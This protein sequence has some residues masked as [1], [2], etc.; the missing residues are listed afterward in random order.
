MEYLKISHV[1]IRC[2]L[3]NNILFADLRC[4]SYIVDPYILR[5]QGLSGL[6]SHAICPQ[7]I[8]NGNDQLVRPGARTSQP[9]LNRNVDGGVYAF[10]LVIYA[11]F[12]REPELAVFTQH[13]EG[14]SGFA[15]IKIGWDSPIGCGG[16]IILYQSG[17]K[18]WYYRN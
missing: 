3:F 13:E 1:I 18:S 12:Y 5:S 14:L 9:E 7:K 6:V 17:C 10:T 16:C 4:K 2:F 8:P 15:L 11:M